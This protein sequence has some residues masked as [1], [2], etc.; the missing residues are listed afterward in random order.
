MSGGGGASELRHRRVL[1]ALQVT[2]GKRAHLDR[3]DTSWDGGEDFEHLKGK[4]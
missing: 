4:K 3:R 1:E 2:P